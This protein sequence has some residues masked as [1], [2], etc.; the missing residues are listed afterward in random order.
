MISCFCSAGRLGAHVQGSGR[1]SKPPLPVS[2]LLLP[3]VFAPD[4][5]NNAFLNYTSLNATL[6]DP[7]KSKNADP[8]EQRLVGVAPR[9]I[10]PAKIT[11]KQN[12]STVVSIL[13]W[14]Q[15]IEKVFVHESEGVFK[16]EM[17]R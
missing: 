2:Y 4:F 11:S 1:F 14:D 17:N 7:A 3:Q 13:V 8:G 6:M 10:V 12:L 15:A 9:W 5:T 16:M